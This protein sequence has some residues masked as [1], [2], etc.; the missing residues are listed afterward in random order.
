MDAALVVERALTQWGKNSKLLLRRQKRIVNGNILECGVA[1]DGNVLVYRDR[2]I[3][4]VCKHGNGIASL[5][6]IQRS[7]QGREIL[8]AN[9]RNCLDD[10]VPAIGFLKNVA[11][12]DL[13]AGLV[14][15][16][17]AGQLAVYICRADS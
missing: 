8:I 5:R 9:L 10:C 1:G 15:E 12:C 16:S 14:I 3:G 7:L 13:C 17:T 6:C 2:L 11:V 4:D